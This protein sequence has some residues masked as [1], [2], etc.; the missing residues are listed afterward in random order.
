MFTHKLVMAQKFSFA[1]EETF[2][3]LLKGELQR[4]ENLHKTSIRE[5]DGHFGWSALTHVK[6]NTMCCWHSL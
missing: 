5:F 2:P 6:K 1:F 4:K 3:F